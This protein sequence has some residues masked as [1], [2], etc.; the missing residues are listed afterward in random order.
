M[1]C[2]VVLGRL[3]KKCYLNTCIVNSWSDN[4]ELIGSIYAVQ[5]D[6]SHLR[7]KL[8]NGTQFKTFRLFWTMGNWNNPLAYGG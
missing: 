6:D 2:D 5:R 4:S 8:L 3:L 7:L 1:Q